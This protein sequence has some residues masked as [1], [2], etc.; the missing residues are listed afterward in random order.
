MTKIASRFVAPALAA[1][2]MVVA[3]GC[4]SSGSK[5]PQSTGPQ[6]ITLLTHDSFA[7]SKPVLAAFTAQTGIR[8]K[9]NKSEGDAGAALSQAILTKDNPIADVFYGVDNTFLSRALDAGIYEPYMALGLDRVPRALQLDPSHRATP[10]DFGDVCVNYDKEWFAAHSQQ[11]PTTIEDLT[12][13]AYR[14]LTR[15]GGT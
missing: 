6:T 10:I 8:V 5:A 7:V 14:R 9:V 11:P 1:V 3:A 4:S 15:Y 2:L 13:P 12:R